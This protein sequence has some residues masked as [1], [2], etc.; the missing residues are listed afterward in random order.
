MS[1]RHLT[2]GALSQGQLVR[3]GG[4][5]MRPL[6]PGTFDATQGGKVGIRQVPDSDTRVLAAV[7]YTRVL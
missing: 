7:Q 5:N 4:G 2:T 3:G 6:V 1:L